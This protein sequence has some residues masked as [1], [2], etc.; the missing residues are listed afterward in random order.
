MHLLT[1]S[2]IPAYP[3]KIFRAHNFSRALGTTFTITIQTFFSRLKSHVAWHNLYGAVCAGNGLICYDLSVK[4]LNYWRSRFSG[5]LRASFK[6]QTR[7]SQNRWKIKRKQ[8]RK[9][10]TLKSISNFSLRGGW[11]I[12]LQ[13]TSQKVRLH[14]IECI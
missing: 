10:Q 3:K 4:L 1:N 5:I 12:C 2:K 9:P 8:N 11:V 7:C 14:S 13:A 6:P